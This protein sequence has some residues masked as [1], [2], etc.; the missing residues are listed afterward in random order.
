MEI[1]RRSK[2]FLHLHR[3]GAGWINFPDGN[4]PPVRLEKAEKED[5][6]SCSWWGIEELTRENEDLLLGNHRV[7]EANAGLQRRRDA[8]CAAS[9]P[10]ISRL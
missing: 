4:L 8:Q 7:F 3:V 1:K 2:E 9:I 10:Y 6:R 5:K